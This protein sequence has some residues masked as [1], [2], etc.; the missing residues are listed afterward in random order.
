MPCQVARLPEHSDAVRARVVPALLVHRAHMS[1]Q[2]ARHKLKV[3]PAE[4]R[5]PAG[6]ASKKVGPSV[7]ID[8]G[9][10]KCESGGA[11]NGPF[12]HTNEVACV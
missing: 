11:E 2:D 10:E 8:Q 4:T 12:P 1:R 6:Q 5:T 3:D 9:P 7:S